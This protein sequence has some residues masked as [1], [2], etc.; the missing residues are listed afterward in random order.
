LGETVGEPIALSRLKVPKA[1]DLLAS[2][3]RERILSGEYVEGSGLPAERELVVQTGLSRTTVREALRIL[4]VQ[5]LVQIRTGRTGGAFVQRP[6]EG[7]MARTV[8]HIIRGHQIELAALLEIRAALEPY[9]AELAAENGTTEHLA[10]IDSAVLSVG[11]ADGDPERTAEANIQWHVAVARASRNE[12]L[13]GV[14]L[15]LE[16]AVHAAARSSGDGIDE[17]EKKTVREHQAIAAA[18]RARDASAAANLMQKHVTAAA[19]P[20]SSESK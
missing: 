16:R 18:I 6:G 19:P 1:S 10:A 5:G 12:L 20:E 9:C 17:L 11:D 14:A 8:E 2:E 3:L 15:A 4:E 13:A 7:A